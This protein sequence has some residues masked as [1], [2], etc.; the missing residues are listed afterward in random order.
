MALEPRMVLE[1]LS[2]LDRRDPKRKVFGA[3]AHQ[4][5]L[6]PRLAVSIVE[7]FEDRHG[8]RLPDDYRAFITEVGNGGAGPHYGLFPFGQQDDSFD[9]CSWDEGDLIGDPSKPFRHE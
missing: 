7:A 5:K 4:Y 6:N 9:L 2:E 8:L 1:L 3:S